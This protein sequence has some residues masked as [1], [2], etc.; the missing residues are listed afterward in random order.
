M[1][2]VAVTSVKPGVTVRP[3]DTARSSVT[4][5][6]ICSPSAADASSIV[7]VAKAPS[8]LVIVPVAVS[9]AATSVAAPETSRF[10][11]N[12]SS[13]SASASSV[14]AT[15]NVFVSPA[16]PVKVSAAVFAV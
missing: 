15:V 5:N 13:G 16:V 6:V 3:P 1:P 14:V 4:V 11:M 9:V 8:S 10:T 2:S 12:V 7:T